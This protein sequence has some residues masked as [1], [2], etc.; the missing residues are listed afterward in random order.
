V[1][2]TLARAWLIM[3]RRGWGDLFRRSEE[4]LRERDPTDLPRTWNYLAHGLLREGQL[5]DADSL[6]VRIESHPT[7]TGFSRLNCR[8]LQAEYHPSRGQLWHNEEMEAAPGVKKRAGHP[9]AFYFQ[10]TARQS[11][12]SV[13]DAVKRFRL[14]QE[15]FLQDAG[16][17]DHPNIL[18]FLAEC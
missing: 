14:A 1:F 3:G 9:F 16:S 2:N 18:H 8:F 5:D 17:G 10:A 13:V 4:I 12:C 7:L 15:L 11:G 6:L